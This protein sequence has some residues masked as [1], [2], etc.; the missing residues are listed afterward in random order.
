MQQSQQHQFGQDI[1][2]LGQDIV[3]DVDYIGS[4]IGNVGKK[5]F[6]E[7]RHLTRD[8][9]G[10]ISKTASPFDKILHWRSWEVIIHVMF[11]ILFIYIA[12]EFLRHSD[13]RTTTNVLLLLIALGIALQV[14]QNINLKAQLKAN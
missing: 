2:E 9:T 1:R 11:A 13:N 6:G 3:S 5:V 4:G 7:A 10:Y 8:V 14:H 12:Y